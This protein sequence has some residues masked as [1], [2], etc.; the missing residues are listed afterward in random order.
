MLVYSNRL[1]GLACAGLFTCLCFVACGC[2]GPAGASTPSP[3]AEGG[4]VE[5][6]CK[7]VMRLLEDQLRDDKQRDRRGPPLSWHGA[8]FIPFNETIWRSLF[9]ISLAK[10]RLI[11]R[12]QGVVPALLEILADSSLSEEMHFAAGLDLAF[13]D[14][15]RIL[16]A[17]YDACQAG[18][19]TGVDLRECL[20][21]HLPGLEQSFLPPDRRGET[22]TTTWLKSLLPRDYSEVRLELLD[23]IFRED[24]DRKRSI[25]E[26]DARMLRWLNRV[27]GEDFDELLRCEAPDVLAFRN[28]ELA[29]GYD[30]AIVMNTPWGD[31]NR[32]IFESALLRV[33]PNPVDRLACYRLVSIVARYSDDD[34]TDSLDET[35]GPWKPEFK[36]WYWAN[37]AK[38]KYD[39][40]KHRFVIP[41]V[42]C[43][44][45]SKGP[46]TKG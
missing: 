27:R 35:M 37:R 18:R 46:G 7:V 4:T 36:K 8:S 3:H 5:V 32:A 12:G 19:L 9:P 45:S 40:T 17:Y 14:D 38:F 6:D 11:R 42:V 20:R 2:A 25:Q 23:Y 15:P 29:R 16:G 30:P 10:Q 22:Q 43:Q 41:D 33:F 21:R 26:D 31:D 34:F 13:F 1:C 39:F 24:D 28:R 44:P